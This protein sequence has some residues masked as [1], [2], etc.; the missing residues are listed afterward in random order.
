MRLG[1]N[2][3]RGA[4]RA[5]IAIH[6]DTFERDPFN[7]RVLRPKSFTTSRFY[8]R[9]TAVFPRS[10]V[11]GTVESVKILQCSLANAITLIDRSIATAHKT[12][13]NRPQQRH[14][15]STFNNIMKFIPTI[16]PLL[17]VA[18]TTADL[19]TR[20]DRK[21]GGGV[22][23][24]SSSSARTR[25]AMA[26]EEVDVA[27]L[28]KDKNNDSGGCA[29]TYPVV[30]IEQ[31]GVSIAMSFVLSYLAFPEVDP[32]VGEAYPWPLQSSDFPS[33]EALF[34]DDLSFNNS[35]EV[36]GAIATIYVEMSCEEY[37]K[38]EQYSSLIKLINNVGNGGITD[39]LST[40]LPVDLT[41]MGMG[42]TFTP[43]DSSKNSMP[44]PETEDSEE[45]DVTDSLM[46]KKDGSGSCAGK[47]PVVAIEQVLVAFVMTKLL[48]S[49]NP[50][51]PWEGPLSFSA[52][53]TLRALFGDDIDATFS[54]PFE[55]AVAINSI[56][57]EM[58]CEEYE[59]EEQFSSLIKLGSGPIDLLFILPF[60]V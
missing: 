31:L 26:D 60:V 55:L 43:G 22:G 36:A 27:D 53:P 25:M 48:F 19:N 15:T 16:L 7:R 2:T 30:A 32:R 54:D 56:Y 17:L 42:H 40:L 46:V 21:L 34:G 4:N 47:Y 33:M 20:S 24:K 57:A 13:T 6:Q 12:L 9:P 23:G 28:H 44:T 51:E 49:L 1:K 29:G 8:G 45:V 59:K 38:E 41:R 50:F 37:E 39:L 10:L 58:S 11:V 3:V 18:S 5:Q 52:S 35:S 14:C